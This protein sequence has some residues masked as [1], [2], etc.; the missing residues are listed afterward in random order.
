LAEC[1]AVYEEMPGWQEELTAISSY[2]QLPE[3]AKKYVER[4]EELTKVP[5]SILAVGPGRDQTIVRRTIF[6]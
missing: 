1:E 4:I 6:S 2:D 3:Q 5:I